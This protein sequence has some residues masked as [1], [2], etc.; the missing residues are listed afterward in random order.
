MSRLQQCLISILMAT[1][2]VLRQSFD[3]FYAFNGFTAK[4]SHQYKLGFSKT[5]LNIKVRSVHVKLSRVS[6]CRWK[7]DNMSL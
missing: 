5:T 2:S 7:K 6:A 1:V 3:T 4:D